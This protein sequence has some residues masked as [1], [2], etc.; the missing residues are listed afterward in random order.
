MEM[1]RSVNIGRHAKLRE[2]ETLYIFAVTLEK[3]RDNLRFLTE[4]FERYEVMKHKEIITAIEYFTHVL[5][6][7]PHSSL[8]SCFHNSYSLLQSCLNVCLAVVLCTSNLG[9]CF[10]Y[11]KFKKL[12]YQFPSIKQ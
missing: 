3:M 6:T 8:L 10:H 4:T 12:K 11:S 2:N 1:E 9:Q 7:V 5:L